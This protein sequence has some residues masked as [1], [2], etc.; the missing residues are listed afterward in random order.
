MDSSEY[1]DVFAAEA[2]EY[3]QLLNENLLQFEEDPNDPEII[4][5]MFRAAHSLKGM[6]GT[7]GYTEM[8]E[9]THHMENVLDSLRNDEI[10][11]SAELVNTMFESVD[12]LETILEEVIATDTVST[13][14]QGITQKL[15]SLARGESLEASSASEDKTSRSVTEGTIVLDEYDAALIKE[16]KASGKKAYEITVVMRPDVVLKSVRAFTVFQVFDKLGTVA[17]SVPS[18]QD[19]DEDR[20]DDRFSVVFISDEG[21]PEIQ[22]AILGIP[23]I[24]E[25]IVEPIGDDRLNIRQSSG[26]TP[27]RGK[28]SAEP[29][30][31]NGEKQADHAGTGGKA[32][33][34]SKSKPVHKPMKRMAGSDKFVRVET[35]RLDALVDLVGE[36]VIS[37]TQ[38]AEVAKNLTDSYAKST[39]AQLDRVT[40]ELQYAAMKLRMVPLKQ[41]FDRFPRLVRD[42]AQEVNKQVEF[43]VRG[44]ETELDRSIVNQIADP[45]VHLLRNAL[46]HGLESQEEREASGKPIRGRVV[47]EARHEG[48]HVV[49]E[50]SDDGRG[51]DV[52]KVKAKAIERGLI[53]S[54]QA[55]RM[56]DTDAMKL[57]FEPGFSTSDVVTDISGRGVGMD[58]VKSAV[59][60][61]DGTVEIESKRGL[62]TRTRLRLPLTLAIIRALLVSV[63]GEPIAVPV[64]SVRE[65]LLVDDA[66][67]KTA[68]GARM[69]T[70]RNQV[71]PLLDLADW[72]GFAATP[73]KNTY[74]VIVVQSGEAT[75][76]LIVDELIGQ[77]E[78]VIKSLSPI[79]GEVKG[80]AGATVLGDGRV[81][82]ILE[83]S[84][85]LSSM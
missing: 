41:V 73:K 27:G 11:A 35:E 39:V 50:V 74:P 71:L 69:I 72:F 38:V 60:A 12:A 7:M 80:I 15:E 30:L 70:L 13:D 55:S 51:I 8:A 83:A 79:L 75:V 44:E 68:H 19:I 54:D 85:V 37:R 77:Q 63:D 78:I 47:L 14:V 61:L 82:L 32:A 65:S 29:E 23:E 28:G 57:I 10:A 5:E 2:R 24:V 36:L 31:S 1:K 34:T 43:E 46:D 56:S 21:A 76:G 84:A 20:F 66:Q 48:S 58:A 64:Q 26:N 18:A 45:L 6:A 52:D 4:A 62:G 67:I 59:E 25:A 9:F 49:I 17:K 42:L 53:T 40:T 22:K 16:A 33:G 81:A 3:I